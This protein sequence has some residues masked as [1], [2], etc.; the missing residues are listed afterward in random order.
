[1]N[2]LV[3]KKIFYALAFSCCAT[4]KA[5][6]QEEI[7][8][9]NKAIHQKFFEKESF[10]MG[11]FNEKEYYQPALHN[12]ETITLDH[13]LKKCANS[14]H[15]GY[16]KTC[17]QKEISKRLFDMIMNRVDQFSR[18]KVNGISGLSENQKQT[19]VST[20]RSE[21]NREL[22]NVIDTS[23][24]EVKRHG[25]ATFLATYAYIQN[26]HDELDKKIDAD[27]QRE[28]ARLKQPSLATYPKQSNEQPLSY[29]SPYPSS[30]V[31]P[32]AP[33]HS[34]VMRTSC[35]S[36]GS[37]NSLVKIPCGHSLCQNHFARLDR[38]PSCLIPF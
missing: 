30:S 6:S 15:Y 18:N 19:I 20:I 32:S 29:Q 24:G 34:S 28:V 10:W 13:A 8:A 1:M 38:C 3:T 7:T 5:A 22:N 33:S 36:C 21:E 2:N 27:V 23:F 26:K 17:A 25:Y 16:D 35:L 12:K 9:L 31:E 4:V 11:W 14:R 37:Q